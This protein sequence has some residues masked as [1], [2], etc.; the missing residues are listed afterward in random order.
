MECRYKEKD[1]CTYSNRNCNPNALSCYKNHKPKNLVI[2][3]IP[4]A[5]A[6]LD[7][8]K[9]SIDSNL[10]PIKY[11]KTVL[12][13]EKTVIYVFGGALSIKK[14]K[15]K[16]Y[17]IIVDDIVDK[18]RKL[19]LYVICNTNNGDFYMGEQVLKYYMKKN[20]RPNVIFRYA[21]SNTCTR[22]LSSIDMSEMSILKMYGY[23]VGKSGLSMQQRHA[24]LEHILDNKI[25]KGHDIISLL[26]FN[27]SMREHES[28]FSQAITD[29]K[30]DIGFVAH[31]FD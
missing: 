22:T 3:P 20:Y 25:M 1:Y 8:K 11:D 17:K 13:H 24:L 10:F 30:N 21:G 14:K 23:T 6:S 27:I 16:D 2:A 9:S 19:S 7:E 15:L 5:T 26:Q 28:R 29:W 18:T 12:I 31:Y 4:K